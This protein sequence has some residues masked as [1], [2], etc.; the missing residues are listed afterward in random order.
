MLESLPSLPGYLHS[1]V[2]EEYLWDCKQLGAYSPI[3]LL[4]TLL[5]FCTKFFQ[6]KTVAQHRQLS[7]A[8]VMRCTK[9]IHD[10]TKS[11]FL[12]FYP[13]IPKKDLAT[14]T[15]GALPIWFSPPSLYG[16]SSVATETVFEFNMF[17]F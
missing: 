17:L 1:R 7:F 2:E 12:R 11:N 15:A 13:P 10:N 5:F 4:N 8:H 16:A 6:F 14:E 3:V 9:S